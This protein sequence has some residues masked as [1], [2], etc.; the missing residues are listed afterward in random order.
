MRYGVQGMLASIS[1]GD[2]Y[3]TTRLQGKGYMS[4]D[5]NIT[6]GNGFFKQLTIRGIGRG[7]LFCDQ[8]QNVTGTIGKLITATGWGSSHLI[9]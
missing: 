5:Y 4:G 1:S 3:S 6:I 7:E 2:V 8:S 9:R